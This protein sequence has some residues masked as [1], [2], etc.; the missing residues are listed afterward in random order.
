M[1]PTGPR[2]TMSRGCAA[3][4]PSRSPSSHA[5]ASKFQHNRALSE[6]P[7]HEPRSAS[8][9]NVTT[10]AHPSFSATEPGPTARACP[11]GLA[12]LESVPSLASVDTKYV[13]SLATVVQHKVLGLPWLAHPSSSATEPCPEASTVSC[14][15]VT[16]CGGRG[17]AAP[18]PSRSPPCPGARIPTARTLNN[19]GLG[20]GG[21]SCNCRHCERSCL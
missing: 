9:Q 11:K 3:L 21:L 20:N 15:N 7:D 16:T 6:S 18:T 13:R 1:N 10:P 4:T 14:H 8:C 17:G 2:A 12:W 5:S 19:F